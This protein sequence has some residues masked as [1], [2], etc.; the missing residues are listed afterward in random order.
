[1][2]DKPRQPGR[3]VCEAITPVPGTLGAGG[4]AHGEPALPGRFVWRGREYQ[5]AALLNSW[6]GYRAEGHAAGGEMYLRK[7][8]YRIATS[9]GEE[10]TIYCDRAPRNPRRPKQR[11]WLYTLHVPAADPPRLPPDV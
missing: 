2:G 10:M 11:W 3:F 6:K 4:M 5:V 7:H 1:M 9:S 8:W